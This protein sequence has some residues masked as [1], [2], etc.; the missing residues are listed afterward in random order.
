MWRSLWAKTNSNRSRPS[1]HY[2]KA[3]SK[4]KPTDQCHYSNTWSS[5]WGDNE[6]WLG[7][8][9]WLQC[10]K[11]N[12]AE[13]KQNNNKQKPTHT[14]VYTKKR[15][16][17]WHLCVK[18][19]SCTLMSAYIWRLFNFDVNICFKTVQLDVNITT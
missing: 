9:I 3:H 7:R 5:L 14:L 15:Q 4:L 2:V 13:Q 16:K 12:G 17:D 18:T 6:L 1:V 19:T 11:V 10:L 8:Q